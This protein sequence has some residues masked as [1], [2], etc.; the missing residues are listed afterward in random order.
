MQVFGGLATSIT[1][2]ETTEGRGLPTGAISWSSFFTEHNI[3]YL[4]EVAPAIPPFPDDWNY[5]QVFPIPMGWFEDIH[6]PEFWDYIRHYGGSCAHMGP[7]TEGAQREYGVE[8]METSEYYDWIPEGEITIHNGMTSERLTAAK[9]EN[10]RRRR[11]R[12]IFNGTADAM[13]RLDALT[14]V[15]EHSVD[16]GSFQGGVG[17]SSSSHSLTGQAASSQPF[18]PPYKD[19]GNDFESLSDIETEDGSEYVPYCPRYDEFK[20]YMLDNTGQG[21]LCFDTMTVA[22]SEPTLCQYIQSYGGLNITPE[23]LT[24]FLKNCHMNQELFRSGSSC[25]VS[26]MKRTDK[27]S[28][29]TAGN[30]VVQW[31]K[32]NLPSPS[33]MNL[34]NLP[35]GDP[36]QEEILRFH[37]LCT[38]HFRAR[39]FTQDLDFDYLLKNLQYLDQKVN[40]ARETWL[41]TFKLKRLI[42]WHDMNHQEG[43]LWCWGPCGVVRRV[44]RSWPAPPPKLSTESDSTE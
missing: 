40:H 32:A 5:F 41:D 23:E 11:A 22:I 10:R 29:S 12:R 34:R 6:T 8:A 4:D 33:S 27:I 43:L 14:E 16:E 7:R 35:H 15:Y 3:H 1:E 2:H 42:D 44:E 31:M 25:N 24:D 28:Y 37:T 13:T 30:G 36:P 18:S 19:L 9:M 26:L 21:K 38:R 17:A 20:K 39:T